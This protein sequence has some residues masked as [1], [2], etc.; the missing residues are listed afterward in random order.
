M[1]IRS[2]LSFAIRFSAKCPRVFANSPLVL[3]GRILHLLRPPPRLLRP[4]R[5][6]RCSPRRP[7]DSSSHPPLAAPHSFESRTQASK[8]RRAEAAHLRLAVE[9]SQRGR[10]LALLPHCR[11]P[12]R[13]HASEQSRSAQ[14]HQLQRIEGDAS[15]VWSSHGMLQWTIEQSSEPTGL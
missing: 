7:R 10:R 9:E 8:C 11:R 1:Q 4:A 3:D 5:R 14:S 2:R 13:K 6:R 15:R 12:Y